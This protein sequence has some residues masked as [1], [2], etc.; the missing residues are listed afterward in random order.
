MISPLLFV[1]IRFLIFEI[2]AAKPRLK[3]L[4]NKVFYS[5]DIVFYFNELIYDKLKTLF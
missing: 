4:T 5:N 1:L 3:E 2:N